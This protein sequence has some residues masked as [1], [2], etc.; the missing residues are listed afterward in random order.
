MINNITKTR[1]KDGTIITFDTCKMKYGLIDKRNHIHLECIYD[2][3]SLFSDN[4]AEVVKDGKIGLVNN[5]GDIILECKY[6]AISKFDNNN[7]ARVMYNG[8]EGLFSI[9]EQWIFKPSSVIIFPAYRDK[10]IVCENKYVKKQAQ[11]ISYKNN[12]TEYHRGN[13][14]ILKDYDL[15]G[16]NREY[17]FPNGKYY[18]INS[19]GNKIGDLEYDLIYPFT[20]GVA[21]VVK[22]FKMGLIDEFGIVTVPII[23]EKIKEPSNGYC[24]AMSN[25][26]WGVINKFGDIIVPMLYEKA[27]YFSD[28]QIAMQDTN[29]IFYFNF[30]G[31]LIKRE[32]KYIIPRL[33]IGA[34]LYSWSNCFEKKEYEFY[35]FI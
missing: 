30:K 5:R 15:I 26:R 18:I 22:D 10:Y 24:F 32:K 14:Y 1:R 17:K 25:N 20:E 9:Y 34:D 7:V 27:L 35:V 19:S 21:R 11:A 23:Y 16:N 3:I 13:F 6:D 31:E 2:A 12:H 29:D 8:M 28:S 4:Y 33:D